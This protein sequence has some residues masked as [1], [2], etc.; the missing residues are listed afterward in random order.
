MALYALGDLHL[1]FQRPEKSMDAMG[2]VL[3]RHE[4]KIWKNCQELVQPGDTLVLV[5]DHSWGR[6]LYQCREDLDFIA[7]LPGRKI[8]IRGNHDMFWEAQ[9]TDSLNQEYAGKLFFLQN[10]FAAYGDYALVGTKGFTFEGPFLINRFTGEVLS[11]DQ[12]AEKH[13][14]KL[15]RREAIRLEDSFRKAQDAGYRKF[16]V[17]LH[18]PPTNILEEESIF[19]RMAERYGA[20][21]VIY[22][23]CHGE[24]QFQ[25]SILG[26][27]KGI[28]YRLVSG[29]YLDFRPEKILD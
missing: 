4:E 20:E 10:N 26:L 13:A 25:D 9:K 2:P 11:W 22:A 28:R 18:Y 16:L 6:K 1:A 29:D 3:V 15:V 8:L 17:F 12:E 21:Q 23:H 7:N 24:A 27:H 19:T 14:Q 5:G